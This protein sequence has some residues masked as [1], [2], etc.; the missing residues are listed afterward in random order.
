[1]MTQRLTLRLNQALHRRLQAAARLRHTTLSALGRHAIQAFL[2]QAG[3]ADGQLPHVVQPS[4]P[5]AATWEMLLAS[6][7]GEV[8]VVVHQ[9]VDCTGL[10][11]AD[12]VRSFVISAVTDAAGA[13]PRPG[14]SLETPASSLV[15]NKTRENANGG[16]HG[17]WNHE[18]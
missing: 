13:P 4:A 10:S 8:Q 18:H 15:S 14:A 7:P 2:A 6:C 3:S 1:M 12:V 5:L 17:R 16:E 11:I 9:M